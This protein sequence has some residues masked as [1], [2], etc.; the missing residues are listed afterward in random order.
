MEKV[1]TLGLTEIQVGEAQTNGTM[2]QTMAKIGMVYQERCSLE[3]DAPEVIEHFEENNPT[4]VVRFVQQKP[5]K[6]KFAVIFDDL[7]LLEDFVGGKV[8]AD[9]WNYSATAIKNKAL[10]IKP[11]QGFVFDMPNANISASLKGDFT[12]KGIFLVEIEAVPM[13]VTAGS[14]LQ[15]YKAK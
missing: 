12:K 1:I 5:P 15:V 3:Q 11:I 9:K 13:N 7:K 6:V 8:T 4:P 10:R 2:P 14:P